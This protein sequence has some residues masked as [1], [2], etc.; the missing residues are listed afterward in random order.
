[1]N[2]VNELQVFFCFYNIFMSIFIM[3]FEL[4]LSGIGNAY[5]LSQP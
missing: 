3:T 5:Q 1:M 2:E 4:F